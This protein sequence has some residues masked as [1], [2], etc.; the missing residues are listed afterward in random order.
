[1]AEAGWYQDPEHPARVRWWDG[2]QWTAH[3]Q[4][5]WTPPAPAPRPQPPPRPQPVALQDEPGY[6]GGSAA[7]SAYGQ[8][9]NGFAIAAL[10]TGLLGLSLFAVIFGHVGLSQAKRSGG[11]MGG[12]GMAIAGLVLGY[13]GMVLTIAF[14]VFL[15]AAANSIDS[16]PY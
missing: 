12:R 4:E 1:M 3:S 9:S 2:L 6:Q 15:V 7:P 16:Y 13:L 5:R 8:Q 11:A 10:V 14:F